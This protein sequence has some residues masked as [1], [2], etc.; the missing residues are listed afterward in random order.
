VF[1]AEEHT[2]SPIKFRKLEWNAA[3]GKSAAMAAFS[4]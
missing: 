2:L 3:I 1:F 4:F